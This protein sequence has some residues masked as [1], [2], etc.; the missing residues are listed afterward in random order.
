[1]ELRFSSCTLVV[2][3]VGSALGFYRDVLGFT[4]WDDGPVS[5][6]PPSQPD[7]RIVLE[8]PGRGASPADR[9]AIEDLMAKALLSRLVFATDDC[10]GTFERI[11]AAGAEVMQE[12]IDRSGGVRDC[13]FLDPSGNMLRFIQRRET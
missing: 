5:V 12:P 4:V 9:S 13:A 7:V 1:M 2:H 8:P 10:D 11:E 6:G 3:D